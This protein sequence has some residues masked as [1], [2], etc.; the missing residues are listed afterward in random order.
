[1]RLRRRRRSRWHLSAR[2]A[3]EA[4]EQK[5]LRPSL[6]LW[7]EVTTLAEVAAGTLRDDGD[8]LSEDYWGSPSRGEN[9]P[10]LEVIAADTA[11]ADGGSTVRGFGVRATERTSARGRGARGCS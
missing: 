7:L 1:T 5:A 6:F 2:E 9:V 3:V 4:Q 11:S 8:Q 10:S